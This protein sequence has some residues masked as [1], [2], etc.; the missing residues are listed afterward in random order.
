LWAILLRASGWGQ[1]CLRIASSSPELS[2]NIG[3]HLPRLQSRISQVAENF[4]NYSAWHY[5]SV[6]LPLIHGTNSE[7]Q[8]KTSAA[9]LPG[10]GP[11]PRPEDGGAPPATPSLTP[12]PPRAAAPSSSYLGGLSGSAAQRAP[13]PARALDEEYNMVHQAFATDTEDQSPWMYYRWVKSD[14]P[15]MCEE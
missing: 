14:V 10:M 4:S 15:P 1:R 11:S 7:P 13:I 9:P 8:D 5:R 6:L 2:P 12:P 3:G